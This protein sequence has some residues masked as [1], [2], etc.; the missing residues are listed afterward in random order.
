MVTFS[1]E[2]QYAHVTVTFLVDNVCLHMAKKDEIK[3]AF[4]QA[5]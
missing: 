1:P 4:N 2:E 5:A 3:K